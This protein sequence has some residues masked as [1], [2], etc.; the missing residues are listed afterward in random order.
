M[1]QLA[2]MLNPMTFTCCTAPCDVTCAT[3]RDV[4][5][6][7]LIENSPD[8]IFILADQRCV[9]VNAA[10]LRLLCAQHAE[11]VLGRSIFEAL[12]L[13][14]ALPS[15]RREVLFMRLDGAP[16]YA[17]VMVTPCTYQGRPALHVIARTLVDRLTM[18]TPPPFFT[19]YDHLTGLPNRLFL[20]ERLNALIRY[21]SCARRVAVLQLDIDSFNEINTLYGHSV[22]DRLLQAVAA[23]MQQALRKHDLLVRLNG[24]EFGVLLGEVD[25]LVEIEQIIH[26]L[27]ALFA[28]PFSLDD[29][30]L[31]LAVSAGAAVYPDDGHDADVLLKH[32]GL[33]L[34]RAKVQRNTCLFFAEDMCAALTRRRTLEDDLRQALEREELEVFFQPQVALPT[35]TI[36][37]VEAL[38]R[39][40]HAERG[41]VPPSLFIPV[42]EEAGLIEALDEAVMRVAC[43]Q[44]HAWNAAA[45]HPL[46]IAVNLSARQFRRQHLA[47]VVTRVLEETRL[48]PEYLELE[49]TESA[50]ME[51]VDR[52]QV[53]LR[54]LADRGIRIAIDD[55]GTGYSSLSYLKRL[56]VHRIK[57][58]RAFVQDLLRN[59]DDAA[60]VAAIIALSHTLN[61]VVLAEGV[62]TSA[63]LEFL[64]Q[65]GCD[66]VQ[67]DLISP[68]VPW[69]RLAQHV[70][71]TPWW[72]G[73][74]LL[75]TQVAL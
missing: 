35:M 15:V 39:W 61:R 32:A 59:A 10:G 7:G 54:Q 4:C 46:T 21:E 50:V 17:E 68:P 65:H 40:R 8:A 12:R 62:E 36:T 34:H 2:R 14:D 49:I 38:T 67:G 58:A 72:T 74:S 63:Q 42:A 47:E 27:L 53:V 31:H 75:D 22:G 73:P 6:R 56:P 9:F 16:A 44:V 52:A 3:T 5:Y 25:T 57:I 48:A 55:F 28:A 29:Q 43:R 23:R 33:A 60:I 1:D 24:D 69:E 70:L 37:G 18:D 11:Q 51:N 66:D 30:A 45:A 19:Y 20:C 64:H 13:D 41:M 26:R 71:T